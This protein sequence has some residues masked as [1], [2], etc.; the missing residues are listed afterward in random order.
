MPSLI[1][2]NENISS[3]DL[4]NKALLNIE[5]IIGNVAANLKSR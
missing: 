3:V 4:P 5:G 2:T 1:P